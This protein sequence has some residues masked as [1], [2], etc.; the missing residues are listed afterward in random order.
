MAATTAAR[1]VIKMDTPA[2]DFVQLTLLDNI[3]SDIN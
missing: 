2:A 3:F 1:M